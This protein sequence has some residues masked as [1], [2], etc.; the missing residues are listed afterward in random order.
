MQCTARTQLQ[1]EDT[2]THKT[3]AVVH[4]CAQHAQAACISK[5]APPRAAA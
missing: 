1:E 5:A 3:T 2:C 4:T